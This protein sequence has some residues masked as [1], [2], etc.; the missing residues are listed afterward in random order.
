MFVYNLVQM[1]FN[2]YSLGLELNQVLNYS[3]VNLPIQ[4]NRNR[5][6]YVYTQFTYRLE[7]GV[8]QPKL[9]L[10]Q[11]CGNVV[12]YNYIFRWFWLQFS[13]QLI[14]TALRYRCAGGVIGLFVFCMLYISC[15]EH[16]NFPFQ[17]VLPTCMYF[18]YLFLTCNYCTGSK[19]LF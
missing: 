7:L 14:A 5:V 3:L 15:Y 12:T 11:K 1:Y 9:D 6:S 16:T 4:I 10:N 13:L 8:P 2:E 18:P 17:I 19:S